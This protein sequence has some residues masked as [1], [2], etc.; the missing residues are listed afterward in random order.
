[1][2]G[3]ACS[4]AL[5]RLSLVPRRPMGS[6]RIGV[7]ARRHMSEAA[8]VKPTPS[9]GAAAPAAGT[10]AAAAV[11][12]EGW[13]L[14][15]RI[16]FFS[17]FMAVGS[18]ASLSYVLATDEDVLFQVQEKAPAVVSFLAPWIGLPVVEETGE[19]DEDAFFPRD[20]SELVGDSVEVACM[21]RSGKVVL[22]EVPP[23]ANQNE[24]EAALMRKLEVSSLDADPL[25]NTTTV[26]DDEA[27]QLASKSS[28]ELQNV[29][30]ID[31]TPVPATGT[32]SK[33]DLKRLLAYY[34]ARE[35]EFKTQVQLGVNHG[36]DTSQYQRALEQVE[37]LKVQVKAEI[38]KAR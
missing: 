3:R 21:L 11:E 19:L 23:S 31:L 20:I 36:H 7:S 32:A 24:L 22:V 16:F 35:F 29:F 14:G 33:D 30:S 4:G 38:K 26:D 1:V 25:V 15:W 8:V 6:S 5:R 13:S 9:G 17:T 27:K 28:E 37:Q 10:P 34:R 12:E 18:T 2:G